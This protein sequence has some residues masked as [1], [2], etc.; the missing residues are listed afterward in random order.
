MCVEEFSLH[1][2]EVTEVYKLLRELVGGYWLCFTHEFC[3]F[4]S[5]YDD[6]TVLSR[7]KYLD[8]V[9]SVRDGCEAYLPK[10]TM[11]HHSSCKCYFGCRCWYEDFYRTKR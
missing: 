5:I 3:L 4:L 8:T 1:T 11:E 7:K 6:R 9:C 10:T 2:D